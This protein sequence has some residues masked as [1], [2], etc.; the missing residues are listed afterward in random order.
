[1]LNLKIVQD[2]ISK[3]NY[4]FPIVAG[5]GR[6]CVKLNYF[7]IRKLMQKIICMILDFARTHSRKVR[8]ELQILR[9]LLLLKRRKPGLMMARF[10]FPR[11][12]LFVQ[13]VF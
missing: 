1:M 12:I 10:D 5:I 6:M 7:I 3:I 9:K 13:K 2:S 4:R 8:A 11:V